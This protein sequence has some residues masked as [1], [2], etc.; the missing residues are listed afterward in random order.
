M[1]EANESNPEKKLEPGGNPIPVPRPEKPL[2]PSVDSNQVMDAAS[3]K[4]TSSNP[5]STGDAAKTAAATETKAGKANRSV[6]DKDYDV[7]GSGK[8]SK[9][10]HP[11]VRPHA[12]VVM[13]FGNKKG[14]DG[15]PF[16]FNAIYKTLIKP[17]IEDA[18]FEP[19]RADEETSSGDILTDMFQELL[20]ADMVVCD[21]SID[22]ANA[23]YELG[24]RH[25]L[26]KRGVVHIQAGRPY[27]PFDVFNVR[28]LPY[29]I[30]P[31]GV[32]DP[33]HIRNDIK[34]VAR[35]IRD[36][37][38]SDRDMVHSP[39]YNLLTGLKE[40]NRKSLQTPLATGFWREYEEWKDR[41]TVA[42]RDKHIGD[43][44]L[45]TEEIRNPL[46]REDAV[47]EVGSA[48]SRL[49]RDELA[50]KQYREGISVNASNLEFRQEEAFHLNRVGRVNEAI[51][52]LENILKDYPEDNKSIS[53]L[54]RI[55]KEMWTG[56]WRKVNDKKKRLKVAFDS[57]HWLIRS[58]EIYMKGFQVDL[59]DYY[60][61][62]NAFTLSMLAIHLA[63]KFDNKKAPDPDIIRIRKRLNGLRETLQ[64]CLE[65]RLNLDQDN[66]DYWALVSM[67]ELRLFTSNDLQEVLRSYRKAV[68][69]VRRDLFS[70]RS[71]LQQLEIIQSLD[72][73]PE[74]VSACINLIKEEIKIASTG[75]AG[76]IAQVDIRPGSKSKSGRALVFSG[77]MVD[78]TGKDKK[79]F[80]SEK[81]GEIRQ[82]IRKRVEKFKA[83][84]L[85][86][87]F[88]AGL[89]AGSEI[90]FAEVCA[91]AGIK[92]KVFMPH[93]DSTYI[94]R[95]VAP[96]G[97][98]WVDRFYSIRNHPLVDEI[99]QIE[100]LGQPKDGDNLYER[101]CRWAIYS[102]MGR[103][104]IANMEMVAVASDFISDTKDR[105]VLLTRY[106]IDLMR[107][108]G[109]RVD[110]FINPTK[111]IR[112][113]IDSALER[114]ILQGDENAQ[115][116]KKSGSSSTKSI[117][118]KRVEKKTE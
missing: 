15:H 27:M 18:G 94:R 42:Q 14:P 96:A 48:L 113:V 40:P 102:A 95:F 59:R 22:N 65:S 54:G 75:D 44:L 39:I 32:P 82:E 110:E 31:E 80:P 70:L 41:V 30:T 36:T 103:V 88:L 101:N 19:F 1:P 37:W 52:K 53:Y 85:D 12:F 61:G 49:G 71:S 116:G 25:S 87:A 97:E 109:G 17:A 56:A 29:H 23:F 57:Y 28:T 105:D 81:E 93:P 72:V 67:A 99:Y 35:L 69:A 89:S 64:F 76:N 112:N 5:A 11:E 86:R 16:D 106:M 46:I 58:I 83:T 73:R 68:T 45:L 8:D 118:R 38:A 98:A 6:D 47:A 51:V 115:S 13:P 2:T 24:I 78:Y 90:I 66:A 111:Y 7:D 60:P 108:L 10:L 104:G 26:R 107:N 100:H 63:D 3:S 84:A 4:A 20:L 117:R 9:N 114:L 55:Y 43:I 77:Y 79:T 92:V 50:L 34:A 74:F 33:I 91:E 21:L 62:I